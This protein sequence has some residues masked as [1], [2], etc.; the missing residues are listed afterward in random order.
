MLNSY[1]IYYKN[2]CLRLYCD[3]ESTPPH[4]HTSNMGLEFLNYD[5]T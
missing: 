5:D 1:I 2:I 4:K 3:P